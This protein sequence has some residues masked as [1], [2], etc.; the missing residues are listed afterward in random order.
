MVWFLCSIC[1]TQHSA[2]VR[3]LQCDRCSDPNKWKCTDCLEMSAEAYDA[4][5]D[6]KELCWFCK[7]CSENV[8]KTKHSKEDKVLGL[9]ERVMDKLCSMEERLKEKVDVNVFEELEGKYRSY[10]RT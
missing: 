9:F 4:L 5:I 8:V 3:A 2:D 6:C 7:G 10:R 1:G